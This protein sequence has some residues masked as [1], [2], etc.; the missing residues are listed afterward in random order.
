MQLPPADDEL[1][2]TTLTKKAL[3]DAGGLQ[4]WQAA[5]AVKLAELIDT[6]RHGTSGPAGNIKA[7]REA[8]AVAI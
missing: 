8:M 5:A 1:S 3:K 7:H 6:N 4:T 2:L